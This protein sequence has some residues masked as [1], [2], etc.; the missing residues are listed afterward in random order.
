[1]ESAPG[2]TTDH[3]PACSEWFSY[4]S[5]LD[6]TVPCPTAPNTL[7]RCVPELAKANT[8]RQSTRST[9]RLTT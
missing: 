8:L 7:L 1:M 2:N 3:P 6:K 4:R 5:A 9:Q